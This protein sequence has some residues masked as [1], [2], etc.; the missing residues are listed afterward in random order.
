MRRNQ[1]NPLTVEITSDEFASLRER[2]ATDYPS[3]EATRVFAEAAPLDVPLVEPVVEVRDK[4]LDEVEASGNTDPLHV[5]TGE[6]VYAYAITIPPADLGVAKAALE[7]EGFG[8]VAAA[9][10]ATAS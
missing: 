8:D 5:Q 3:S 6:T 2:L 10:Q 1:R 4:T 9:L 7:A